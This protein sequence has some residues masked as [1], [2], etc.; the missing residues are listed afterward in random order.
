MWTPR[1]VLSSYSWFL[2]LWICLLR[3]FSF[4]SHIEREES[5]SHEEARQFTVK[6]YYLDR[7][8]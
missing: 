6:D 3:L 1:G 4:T 5:Y 7:L 2:F 8:N